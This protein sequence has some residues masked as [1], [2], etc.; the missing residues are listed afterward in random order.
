MTMSIESSPLLAALLKRHSTGPKHLVEPGPTDA[1]LLTLTAAALRAPDHAALVPFRF[2]AV[3]GAARDRMACLF[4]AAALA[5]GKDAQGAAL[6]RERALRAPVTLAVIAKLD[7]GHPQVP[8]HEQW[9]CLGGALAHLL[10]AAQSLGY[11]AKML[12]GAKARSPLLTQAFCDSG[13]TLVGWVSIG[14]PS[15]QGHAKPGKP[16]P[17]AVLSFWS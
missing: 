4:E 14:T 7:L 10:L 13:E 11:G 5:A 8:V 2:R 17:S 3:R 6:D 9:V 1:E 16:D 12:S 15:Q